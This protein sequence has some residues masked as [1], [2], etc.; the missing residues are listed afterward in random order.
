M[1]SADEVVAIHETLVSDFGQSADPISPAGVRSRALLESAVGRQWT[2]L[3]GV[4]KYPHPVDNAATLLYGICCDHPFHNGNK[5]TALV[6]MLVHLDRSQ[7]TLFDTS[8]NELYDLMVAVAGHTLDTKFAKRGRAKH[9]TRQTADDE[10]EALAQWLRKRADRVKKGEKII[11]YRELRKILGDFGYQL[12]DPN[13]NRIDVVRYVKEKKGLL[14][15]REVQVRKRIGTIPWPGE[16]REVG[17]RDLK[18][19]REIC[20]LREQDGID[21]ISFYDYA[22]VVDSFVNR[23]RKVLRRLAKT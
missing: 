16:T 17:L 11:T 5:R 10:V 23:Y 19:V 9:K 7:H 22:V 8:Q 6:S 1:L 20:H 14:P 18:M 2:S 4:L 12:E 13:G 3:D 15:R 21:S